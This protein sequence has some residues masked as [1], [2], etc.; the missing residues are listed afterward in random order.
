MIGQ[1][2]SHY[3]IL[4]K[5]G[6][7]G[8]GEVYLAEDTKLHRR[9]ALKLLPAYLTRNAEARARFEREAQAEAA[10][11][12]PNIVIIHDTGDLD[13]QVYIVMEYVEGKSLRELMDQRELSL[14]Q[15]IEIALQICE[16]L[17]KAHQAGIVHRDIKPENIMID[18]DGR[19]KILDFGLAMLK[20]TSRLT[21]EIAV[22]GTIYYISPEQGLGEPIDHRTDIWSLGVMLYEMVADRLPFSGDAIPYQILNEEPPPLSS[23]RYEV[24]EELELILKKAMQKDRNRRYQQIDEMW[25]DLRPLLGNPKSGPPGS[26]SESGPSGELR[27][28]ERGPEAFPST[29]SRPV[30][31]PSEEQAQSPSLQ[32]TPGQDRGVD[33]PALKPRS[34]PFNFLRLVQNKLRSSIFAGLLLLTVGGLYLFGDFR[35]SQ[36]KDPVVLNK[37]H[38]AVLPFANISRDAGDE[39]F[40]DGMTEELISSLSKIGGFKVIARTSVMKYKGADKNVAEIGQELKVGTILEGSVRKADDKLRITVQLI[41]VGSQAH[42]WSQEYDRELKDVFSI[43]TDIAQQVVEALKMQLMVGEKQQ[44]QKKGTENLE[45]YTWYLRG[46]YYWNRRTVEGLKK[47]IE[48]FEYAIEKDPNYASAYS[49]LADSYTLLAVYGHLPPKEAYP[50]AKQA[51][52]K[53]LEIDDTLAEAHT[54]LAFARH[55]FDWDWAGAEREFKRALSLNPG[56]STAHHW[57]SLYLMQMGRTEE[58]LTEIKRA[59]ELDPFSLPINTDIGIHFYYARQYDRAIQQFQKTLKID[60]D[61]ARAYLDLGLAYEQKGMYGEA[62][63]ALQKGIT[64]SKGSMI[65]VATVARTYALSGRKSD[66]QRVLN[67]LKAKSNQEYV[68]A[69]YFAPIYAGLG[70]QDQALEWLQKAYEE[71]S[72]W[73]VFLKIN[74]VFDGLHGDPRF[75]A[76]LQKVGLEN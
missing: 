12:H 62:I 35:F 29:G 33:L 15:V 43:Q 10:L 52:G 9:V 75:L 76:L 69:F 60:P 31:R 54:S 23:A 25:L 63:E 1:T 24:P 71:R 66:A 68:P 59:Q 16:G 56:Y 37:H 64:L 58:G 48:Y 8:M 3:R 19:V 14:E 46:R 47:A 74:P 5:L 34:S 40:A 57:Y 45:A 53:A 27:A 11:S 61:F 55:R 65:L 50:K 20:G 2:I 28:E 22:M 26:T 39:Y 67:E 72:G 18:R 44:I 32:K 4:E 21:R 30:V 36:P 7:G 41:D 73:L 17:K 70:E 38:I 13:G 6:E 51:A 49:G 42:L